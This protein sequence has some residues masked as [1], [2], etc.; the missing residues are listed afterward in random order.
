MEAQERLLARARAALDQQRLDEAA[1]TIEAAR[2]AGIATERVA[3]LA[4]E[5]APHASG[6][7]RRRLARRQPRPRIPAR[8]GLRPAAHAPLRSPGRPC[9]GLAARARSAR[10]GPR[11]HGPH[12]RR[13]GGHHPARDERHGRPSVTDATQC[14]ARWILM[15]SAR[16]SLAQDRLVEPENDNAQYYL[17][18]LRKLDP[19]YAGLADLTDDLGG[20]LVA[21]GRASVNAQQYDAARRLARPRGRHRVRLAAGR[22]RAAR[23]R[24]GARAPGIHGRRDHAPISSPWSSR[25]SLS[26]RS[27]PRRARSKDGSSS[28]SPSPRPVPSRMW[29]WTRPNRRGSS[30]Q[31]RPPLYCNGVTS[32]SCA[33][34]RRSPR[35]RA[36][37]FAS[38]SGS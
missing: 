34:P 27:R 26:I 23:S 33:T 6:R 29:R 14:R 19:Q 25:Y 1:S 13:P 31:R 10:L 20:R 9:R 36:F 11:G 18:A 17:L 28:T 15:K 38:P 3:Q 7:R 30:R 22:C 4:T 16:Q 12:G 5:L 37:V 21:K 24:R 8:G 32:R 2:K 35:V